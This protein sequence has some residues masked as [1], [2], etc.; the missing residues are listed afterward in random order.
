MIDVDDFDGD[1]DDVDDVEMLNATAAMNTGIE[2]LNIREECIVSLP[3]DKFL[4][5]GQDL[6]GHAPHQMLIEP[7]SLNRKI[8]T[9]DFNLLCNPGLQED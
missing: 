9:P 3:P 2:Q 8:E 5:V 6:V 1:V 4:E 7:V